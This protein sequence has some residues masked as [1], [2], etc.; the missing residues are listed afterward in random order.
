M[1]VLKA[2][3]ACQS[4]LIDSCSRSPCRTVIIQL[5]HHRIN[6]FNLPLPTSMDYVYQHGSSSGYNHDGLAEEAKPDGLMHGNAL[7]SIGGTDTAGIDET[8]RHDSVTT[9]YDNTEAIDAADGVG[10]GLNGMEAIGAADGARLADVLRNPHGRG[11][12]QRRPPQNVHRMGR[13]AGRG[14]HGA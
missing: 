11:F 12:R 9:G 14:R 7:G 10:I 4:S 1:R 8:G 3:S 6:I 13:Q 5:V 2:E